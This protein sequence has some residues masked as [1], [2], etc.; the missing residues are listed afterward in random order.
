MSNALTDRAWVDHPGS[1][2]VTRACGV[3]EVELGDDVGLPLVHV[4]G[5]GVDAAVGRRPVDGAEHPAG[6]ALDDA[7]HLP[8]PAQRDVVGGPVGVGSSTTRPDGGAAARGRTRASTR[9]GMVGPKT[10]TSAS[11]SGSSA[12][13][14]ARCGAST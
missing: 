10:S 12:A 5:T 11:V 7:H 2:G 14:A 9:A 6:P 1:P 8:G 4:D 3:V 13:A